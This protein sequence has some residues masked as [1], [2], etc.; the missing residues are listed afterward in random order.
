ML[1]LAGQW[2]YPFILANTRSPGLYSFCLLDRGMLLAEMA[3]FVRYTCN[4]NREV[5]LM[6]CSGRIGQHLQQTSQAS[7]CHPHEPGAEKLERRRGGRL[8]F[9]GFCKLWARPK[10]TTLVCFVCELCCQSKNAVSSR[11][12]R[13]PTSCW[14]VPRTVWVWNWNPLPT[15]QTRPQ[16]LMKL[17]GGAC[18]GQPLVL[19]VHSTTL[20]NDL[21]ICRTI[22]LFDIEDI[23]VVCII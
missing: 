10:K 8:C 3:C 18:G 9:R 20:I 2:G 19:Q 15:L 11:I 16:Y 14:L 23:T 4:S 13:Y 1:T 6:W 7:V 5:V 21:D 22:W 12:W 17:L